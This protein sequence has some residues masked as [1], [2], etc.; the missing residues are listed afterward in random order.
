MANKQTTVK[1]QVF[2]HLNTRLELGGTTE[3]SAISNMSQTQIDTF[4]SEFRAN[5]A[6]LIAYPFKDATVNRAVEQWLKAK[7]SK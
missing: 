1:G 7:A 2:N 4:I 6:H 5:N 3:Y